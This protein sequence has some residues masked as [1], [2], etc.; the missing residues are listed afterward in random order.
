LD[1]LTGGG[2]A[3]ARPV[4]LRGNHEEVFLRVLEGDVSSIPGWLRYGGTECAQSYGLG[5]GF[6]LNA[7]PEAIMKRLSIE[8]PPAHVR[9]LNDLADTFRL[10][11][12]LFV[13]AG[14][15]PGVPIE[16]QAGQDLRWIREGF[17]END[18]DHG[19]V[20]VHGHTIV[21]EIQE[22]SNRIALDTGAYRTGVLTAVGVE[23]ENRW[24]LRTGS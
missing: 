15:R 11:D 21:Q 9:F 4:F 8:V 6:L 18:D 22:R 3:S 5:S 12:Y 10:G 2:F 7:Q 19:F 24:Y 23:G 16:E 14:I 17:L 1:L 13:H 20:V